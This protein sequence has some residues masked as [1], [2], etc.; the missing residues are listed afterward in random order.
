MGGGGGGGGIDTLLNG[1][2][3]LENVPTAPPVIRKTNTTYV[4]IGDTLRLNCT[5]DSVSPPSYTWR[6][7]NQPIANTSR[8]TVSNGSGLLFVGQV[9]YNDSG[10]YTCVATNSIGQDAADFIVV[11]QGRALL[12]CMT[13]VQE[14]G[15]VFQFQYPIES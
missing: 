3:Y 11:V 12:L 9:A 1:G 6:S 5:A 10:V 14:H 8:V 7:G 13:K 4:T 2:H 15:P